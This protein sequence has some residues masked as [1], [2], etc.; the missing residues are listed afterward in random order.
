M[1]TIYKMLRINTPQQTLGKSFLEEQG[2]LFWLKKSFFGETIS[3][4]HNF[5]ELETKLNL[6]TVLTPEWKYIYNY[7]NNTEQLYNIKSDHLESNNLI[8][9]EIEQGNQL[10]EKLFKWASSSKRYPTRKHSFKLTPQ[11]EEQ[12]RGLGYIK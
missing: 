11:E 4:N 9:K 10:K 7:E 3:L 8:D 12:L 6:K 2:L 1:P 5:S